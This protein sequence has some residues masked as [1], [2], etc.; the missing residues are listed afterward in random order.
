[1]ST[2][3]GVLIRGKKGLYFISEK[4]MERFKVPHEQEV[5]ALKVLDREGTLKPPATSGR[6]QA[7]HALEGALGVRLGKLDWNQAAINPTIPDKILIDNL[8]NKK[9]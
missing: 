4:D 2:V 1:M 5:P 9:G 7:L 6:L 8:A 3:N